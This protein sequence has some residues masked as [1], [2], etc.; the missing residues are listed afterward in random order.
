MVRHK[1]FL[2]MRRVLSVFQYVFATIYRCFALWHKK[3]K[4]SQ[5]HSP[6]WFFKLLCLCFVP[7]WYSMQSL[8][9]CECW[10]IFF[11]FLLTVS[12]TMQEKINIYRDWEMRKYFH[13][14]QPFFSSR[15]LKFN[16]SDDSR[17][18][19]RKST[20]MTTWTTKKFF[21]GT[22]LTAASW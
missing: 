22:K 20:M 2:M 12:M 5:F 14:F 15:F 11:Y 4:I 19:T 18:W 3:Y 8:M 13:F 10:K 17:D 1:N 7:I 16:F 6:L 9:K 21:K